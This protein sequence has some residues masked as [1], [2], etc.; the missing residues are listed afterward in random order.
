LKTGT[1]F[2]SLNGIMAQRT[3]SEKQF[4]PNSH[5]I[6]QKRAWKRSM[7]MTSKPTSRY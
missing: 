5:L 6:G 4:S 3:K 1:E 7:A 2:F